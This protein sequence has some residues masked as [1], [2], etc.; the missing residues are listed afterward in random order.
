MK[1]YGVDIDGVLTIETHG[2]NYEDRTPRWEI[3]EIINKLYYEGNHITLFS[4]RYPSDK[5]IT[6]RWLNKYGVKFNKLILG[7]PKF[8]I[9]IDDIAIKPEELL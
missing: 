5:I 4:S 2:W 3:I 7:K 6:M 9:Y 8:E 1:R